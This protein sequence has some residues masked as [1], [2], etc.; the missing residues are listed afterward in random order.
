MPSFKP[1]INKPNKSKKSQKFYKCLNN[2]DFSYVDNNSLIKTIKNN[3][4]KNLNSLIF[5]PKNINYSGKS[6]QKIQNNLN[7]KK[8]LKLNESTIYN[9]SIGPKIITATTK[10]IN[11]KS[12]RNK[13]N[14]FDNHIKFNNSKNKSKI[15]EKNLN[16]QNSRNKESDK[17]ED[18]N[19]SFNVFEK[20]KNNKQQKDNYNFI[21]RNEIKNKNKLK[22]KN[23]ITEQREKENN[24]INNI[25]IKHNEELYNEL[26]NASHL[27]NDKKILEQEKLLYNLNIRD[28]TSNTIKQNVI[29]TSKKYSDFFK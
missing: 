15:K 4:R 10:N 5:L 7:N 24:E 22:N 29:L 18:N 23:K 13:N 21:N 28:N 1:L 11:I 20:G 14:S 3:R 9:S 16:G 6:N 19:N 12:K 17:N 8:N 25:D 26:K 2:I 27:K